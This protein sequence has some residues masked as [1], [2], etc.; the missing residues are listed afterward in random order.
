[1]RAREHLQTKRNDPGW[2]RTI[3]TLDVNQVP[4]QSSHG[5]ESR[6]GRSRTLY[7]WVG[8][9]LLSREHTSVL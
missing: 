7:A 5:T 2:N 9:K 8:A 1:M 3:L 6:D 4:H